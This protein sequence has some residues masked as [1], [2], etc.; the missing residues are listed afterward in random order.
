[1]VDKNDYRPLHIPDL[2][3]NLH[4]FIRAISH[5][6]GKMVFSLERAMERQRI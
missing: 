4:V 5:M 3:L 2:I 1:M 6:R